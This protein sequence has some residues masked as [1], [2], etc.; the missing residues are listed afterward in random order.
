MKNIITAIIKSRKNYR[1]THAGRYVYDIGTK[2]ED[3]FLR[4]TAAR[5][6]TED[7]KFELDREIAS[8]KLLH[9]PDHDKPFLGA[10]ELPEVQYVNRITM[11]DLYQA[12][13]DKQLIP[14]HSIHAINLE[15][16]SQR[17]H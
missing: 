10:C 5:N 13:Q 16:I 2:T 9:R 17:L 14:V 12:L 7:N 3:P 11:L 6:V 8:G 1:T 4:N 15:R